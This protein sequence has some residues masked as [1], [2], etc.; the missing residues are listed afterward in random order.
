MHHIHRTLMHQNKHATRVSEG[1]RTT[2]RSKP[3]GSET[4]IG[5]QHE[6]LH[7]GGQNGGAYAHQPEGK[8]TASGRFSQDV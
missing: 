3:E 1:E 8:I 4:T 5:D 2:S 7:L 6:W